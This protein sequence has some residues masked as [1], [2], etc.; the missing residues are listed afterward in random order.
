LSRSFAATKSS[1]EL[2]VVGRFT[3]RNAQCAAAAFSIASGAFSTT[4]A[5][6]GTPISTQRSSASRSRLGSF[7]RGGIRKAS[8]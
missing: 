4:C 5:G 3:G 7:S 8:S 6:H 1:I 2:P